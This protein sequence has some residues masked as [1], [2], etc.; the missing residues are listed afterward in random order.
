MLAAC[1][2]G[3]SGKATG[4]GTGSGSGQAPTTSKSKQVQKVKPAPGT[5]NVQGVVR[6]DDQPVADIEVKLC[7]EFSQFGTGCGGA[8]Y[9]ARTDAGGEYVIPDVPPKEYEALV[10]R[11][12]DTDLFQFAQ[13]GL[14]SA[15]KYTI[16]A[17]K[18]VFVDVTHLFKA[19]LHVIEPASGSQVTGRSLSVRWDPYPNATHYKLGIH[20]S[21]IGA[22]SP[23]LGQRVDGTSFTVPKAL[24]AGTYR[25][26]VEAFN[27]KDRKLSETPD[28]YTFVATGG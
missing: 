10:V 3:G 4:N 2:G 24:T 18:T 21:E 22:D 6:Y 9:K 25:L 23:V 28:D 12:F 14:V 13:S 19:D 1:G 11:V 5:G 15:K 26:S 7:E 27:A 17:D 16:E 8:E 20:A